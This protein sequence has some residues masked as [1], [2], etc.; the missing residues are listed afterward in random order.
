M[1]IP[2]KLVLSES[3]GN[4]PC[5]DRRDG[6]IPGLLPRVVHAGPSQFGSAKIILARRGKL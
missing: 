5:Q 4:L 3:P 6:E 2:T 1:D